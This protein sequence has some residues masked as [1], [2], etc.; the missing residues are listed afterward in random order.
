MTE[1]Q[2]PVAA[3]ATDAPTFRHFIAGEWCESTSEATFEIA[4]TIAIVHGNLVMAQSGQ[5]AVDPK[6]LMTAV[7]TAN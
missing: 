1:S 2:T 7:I 6:D 5:P 4:S 3:T